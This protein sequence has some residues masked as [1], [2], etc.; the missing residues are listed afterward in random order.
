MKKFV[1]PL[2]TVLDYKDQ[3]LSN[4]K[5]EHGRIIEQVSLRENEVN[6]LLDKYA[7]CNATFNKSKLNGIT[8]IE[9]R[10]YEMYLNQLSKEIELEMEKLNQV[11]KAE[12]KKRNEVVEARKETASIEKLKEKKFH[13]YTKELQKK[14]EQFIEEFVSNAMVSSH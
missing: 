4:L 1:F 7:K 11:K 14:D 13:Q 12:E 8:V 9:A 10:N 6:C 3:L 5:I 2:D